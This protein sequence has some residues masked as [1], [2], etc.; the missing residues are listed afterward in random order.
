MNWICS[1]LNLIKG[2]LIPHV[3]H[4]SIAMGWCLGMKLS[5]RS[6]Q[7]IPVMLSLP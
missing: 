2:L 1:H 7:Y 4:T 5:V 3:Y 6:F